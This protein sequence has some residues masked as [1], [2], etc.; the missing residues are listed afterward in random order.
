MTAYVSTAI[1][2][3]NSDPHI[4]FALELVHYVVYTS[5]LLSPY[6]PVLSK[7]IIATLSKPR[8]KKGD[9]LFPPLEPK[10]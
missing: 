5:E 7:K 9:I 4:G 2:Y 8:L 6:M 3:V 10:N 1:P